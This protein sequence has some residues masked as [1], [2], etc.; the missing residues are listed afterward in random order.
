MYKYKINLIS[1]DYW[2]L[3]DNR[4][5]QEVVKGFMTNDVTFMNGGIVIINKNIESVLIEK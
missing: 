1:G 4:E 2:Y 3:E 5:L